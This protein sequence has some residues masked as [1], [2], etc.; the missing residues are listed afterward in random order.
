M[1]SVHAS[2]RRLAGVA[3]FA[4]LVLGMSGAISAQT[5][6]TVAG[7]NGSGSGANQLQF[8]VSIVVHEGTLY[9]ADLVNA[10]V[11]KVSPDGSVTT[12]AGGHSYGS[13]ANQLYYPT[14]I[15][16]DG[17][18]L[19]ISDPENNRIQR[20]VIGE[21]EGT[22]VAGGNGWGS[23]ANQLSY[24]CGIAVDGDIL[25]I[26]DAGNDRIQ[27]WVIG[28]TEGT[29]VA[30]GNG[31]GSAANQLAWPYG[32]VVDGDTLYIVDADIHRIQR[33][34]IGETE[35][36]TVAGGNGGSAA[37]QLND[38]TDIAVDGDILYIADAG[39]DR[40]QRW[41]I[42][43][44]EGTT[45]A[46]GNGPG[47][48]ANQLADPLG[49][50]VDGD[51]LY[52]ADAENNRIQRWVIGETEGTLSPV[53]LRLGF[54][55]G[56]PGQ[57][58]FL[59][60]SL[61]NPNAASVGSLRFQVIRGS[62][63]VEFDSLSFSVPGFTTSTN[64]VGDTTFVLVYSPTSA[65]ILPGTVSLGSLRYRIN[66]DAPLC[67]PIPLTIHGL[68][69]SDSVGNAL[70]DSAVDGEIQAGIPGDL[71]LD[72]QISILDIIKL[73]RVI[74]GKDAEPDSTTCQFFIADFNADDNLDILD[75]IG[76]VNV[77]L[78]IT[79]QIVSSVPTTA[80][81]RFG[82]AQ[83]SESGGLVVPVELQS[84]GLVAGLQATVRFDPSTVSVGT[85][86][87][88]GT[89][90]GL[91]LDASVKDGVLRF[92]V[93]GTQSGQGMAAGSGTFLL[94]PITLRNGSEIPSFEFSNV[95]VASA[96]AQR[97]PVTIGTPV[98]ASALP[99]AFSLSANHPNP[100]NPSTQIAYE[101]PQQAH[102]TLAVYNVLGQEV[103][104]LVNREQ[105]AGRYTVTWDGRNTQGQGV[106]SGV[107]LYRITSSTGF[108]ESRR[109]LLLK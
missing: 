18:M 20:W 15:A 36:T 98:K 67:T 107:Y 91:S 46:G 68:V 77:I 96:Q 22:T 55:F 74:V 104:R 92:V 42:G 43:E 69:I 106:S 52:I 33:W 48:A 95:V 14:D 57:T 47:S 93:V 54:F 8:P 45:V 25:Y 50:A 35:G 101:V 51:M 16:V 105:Q 103:V 56:E 26:A 9:I 3:A 61:T 32:I 84:D 58:E 12:V 87:L 5:V 21:T 83:Q 30:G 13:A 2:F 100:F 37:N 73:V 79:K 53:A 70:P 89:A 65:V 90:S 72:R 27:R 7:G 23:A 17:D 38:P 99:T 62:S 66:L 78:N 94:I 24:P 28:E 108:V 44:T 1:T 19:Y 64:T 34:V 76:Q 6:T 75:V 59:P 4:A 29:T 85:P 82:V 49:I 41:V 11:Q 71:N 63:A 86:Q 80:L 10:R 31:W 102:I 40:I 81:I 39:N 109:M 88:T 60:I 97:V